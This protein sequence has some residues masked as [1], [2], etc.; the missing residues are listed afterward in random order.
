MATSERRNELVVG[1]FLFVGLLLLAGLVLQF[2][3]FEEIFGKQY[4]ITVVF[5]DASGLI[6]GSEVRM[7]GAR[8]GRVAKLPELIENVQVEVLLAID[9]NIR[10]PEGSE[11]QINSAT[12]LG[13]KLIVVIPPEK[14]NGNFIEP[15]SRLPGAGPSGLEALQS[16][17]ENVSRDVSRILKQAEQTL[18]KVDAAVDEIQ[19]ASK[20][21]GESLAKVNRSI[22]AEDNLANFDKTLA[23]LADASN[24][25]KQTSSDLQPALAEARE[26]VGEIKSAAGSFK[27]T[28]AMA[29]QSIAAIEPAIKG[30]PAAVANVSQTA[31]KAGDTLDRMR[32]GEGMLGAFASDNEVAFDFKAFMHNLRRDGVIFYRDETSAPEKAAKERTRWARG[33]RQ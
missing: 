3:R 9:E 10:I 20:Q 21:L 4:R 7:G 8:I 29:D 6:K 17:A 13:D 25:W 12:L 5:D 30:V 32:R 2:G 19:G 1:L 23:N 14:Q 31:A 18:V 33:K 24:D 15:D 22:L 16:Q 28:L 26:A 11:F 27:Q